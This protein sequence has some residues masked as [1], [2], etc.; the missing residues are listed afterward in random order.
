MNRIVMDDLPVG[1][2]SI[3]EAGGKIVSL[4]F[5]DA[6][7]LGCLSP[8]LIDAQNQVRAYFAGTLWRFD[9]PIMLQA[10]T[11]RTLVYQA[12]AQIPYGETLS[13]GQLA[14]R[15]GRPRAVR[16]V[17]QALRQNPIWLI[18]PCHRVLGKNGSLTG[19][20]GGLD[21][22]ALLLKLEQENVDKTK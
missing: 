20:A 13:Y 15:I 1:P 4:K 10:S 21:A 3:A 7:M 12:L 14:E 2:I 6:G 8:V 16:A 5:T 19:F 17:G 18:L 22:K 9:L 11:F